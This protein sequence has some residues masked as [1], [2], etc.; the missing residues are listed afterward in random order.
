MGEDEDFLQP[1]ADPSVERIPDP[2]GVLPVR[3]QLIPHASRL[4]PS[5]MYQTAH[6]SRAAACYCGK[7]AQTTR[8]PCLSVLS[9]RIRL[10]REILQKNRAKTSSK[11]SS[12]WGSPQLSCNERVLKIDCCP[13]YRVQFN[14]VISY[15]EK[16]G[17]TIGPDGLLDEYAAHDF[18]QYSED[19]LGVT[20]LAMSGRQHNDKDFW[21]AFL[22]DLKAASSS[23]TLYS[24]FTGV[25]R[26]SRLT[27]LFQAFLSR[28]VEVRVHC[29]P[30]L[31]QGTNLAEQAKIVIEKLKHLGVQVIERKGMHQKIA[32]IDDRIVWEGSL[33]V[34]SHRD[35]GEQMRRF[36]GAELAAEVTRNLEPAAEENKP[37]PR[38]TPPIS[39]NS[40]AS[41]Q[42]DVAPGQCPQ[43]AAKGYNSKL[44][45]RS[46]RYGEFWGCSSCPRCEYIKR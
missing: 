20:L 9:C 33:N 37:N 16:T 21:P 15:F 31:E 26:V 11:V 40:L 38:S 24:P 4:R 45:K 7:R 29:Q 34:L 3:E 36:E 41:L 23:V 35:T 44:V 32:I 39:R 43:C 10:A 27:D 17:T 6:L 1:T 19:L 25:T 2:G 18:V 42:L 30:P 13:I 14:M 8:S 5:I 12:L 22:H 46:S 28:K